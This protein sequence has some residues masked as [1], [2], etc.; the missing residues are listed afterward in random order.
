MTDRNDEPLETTSVEQLDDHLT[1]TTDQHEVNRILDHIGA[2]YDADS[3]VLEDSYGCLFVD[4]E[5]GDYTEV[6]GVHRSV[7]YKA[8]TAYR[9]R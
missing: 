7:P 5:Q 9:L 1:L 3:I 2:E 4:T 8:A 6:W